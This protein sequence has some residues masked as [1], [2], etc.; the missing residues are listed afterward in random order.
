MVPTKVNDRIIE[1]DILRGFAVLGM[2]LWDFKSRS[3]GNYY[4]AG[5]PD[6]IVSGIIASLDI[7]HSVYLIFSFL[8]GL[9]LEMQ[10]RS[11]AGSS[12][13][14]F[15]YVR[16]LVA[17]FIIGLVNC[18]FWDRTDI[19][20]IYAMMGTFLPLFANLTNRIVLTS[21]LFLI[22]LP[23]IG[24]LILHKFTSYQYY[25]NSAYD[26]LSA[27]VIMHSNYTDLVQ[28]HAKEFIQEHLQA[29]VYIDAMGILGMFL[30]GLYAARWG[31]FEKVMNIGLVRRVLWCSLAVRLVGVEWNDVLQRL[32]T[33]QT[34]GSDWVIRG[35]YLLSF[36]NRPEFAKSLVLS[37]S[38]HALA[39]FYSALI[40]LL[41]QNKRCKTLLRPFASVGRLAL[42]NYLLHCLIGTTLFFGYGLALYGKLGIAVGEVLAI[43]VFAF[44]MVIST[45]WLRRFHFGPVEWLWRSVSYWKR[46]PLRV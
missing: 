32:Q 15:I 28:M 27:Q 10:I 6:R 14:V 24:K 9:G 46:Q 17:L 21:S 5:I 20:Y 16:R 31:V 19:L 35:Y 11:Q 23:S 18:F 26:S 34:S 4:S 38:N 12:Q 33:D 41:L 2:I 36:N 40:I 22:G 37:Y 42:S 13:F 25:S 30:L 7:E 45:C 1:I 3:M 43:S 39:L 8:F 29:G 44:Q